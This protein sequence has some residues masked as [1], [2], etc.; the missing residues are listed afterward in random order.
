M[1]LFS[2]LKIKPP[3]ASLAD[4]EHQLEQATEA[5]AAAD[6]QVSEAEREF[7]ATGAAEALS[8]LQ[9]AR[10]TAAE[11]A[12]HVGRATRLLS[13]AQ[14]RQAAERMDALR[15]EWDRLSAEL[16]PEAVQ[17]AVQPL[18]RKEAEL[19]VELAS[20]RQKRASLAA[21][22]DSRCARLTAIAVE[23]RDRGC[24]P[25]TLGTFV[26]SEDRV[27][28]ELPHLPQTSPLASMVHKIIESGKGR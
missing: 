22:L 18:A 28:A 1:G 20:V 7:D 5:R 4:L 17:L 16:T 23:V 9:A 2:K 6:V 12:E 26:T 10:L 24:G 11:A 8:V 27:W 14:E 15:D 13:A 3:A 19:A 25:R 21:E